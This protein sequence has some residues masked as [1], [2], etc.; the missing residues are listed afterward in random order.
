MYR[1]ELIECWKLSVF[2]S[3]SRMIRGILQ[4]RKVGHCST[5]WLI[6]LEKLTGSSWKFCQRCIFG[7]A[8]VQETHRE[9][10]YRTWRFYDDIV[11]L[12]NTKKTCHVSIVLIVSGNISPSL[13]YLFL[14]P[15]TNYANSKKIVRPVFLWENTNVYV[16]PIVT[17]TSAPTLAVLLSESPRNLSLF[18]IISF[19]NAFGLVLY[20]VHRIYTVSGK[21]VPLDFLP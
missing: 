21:K 6:S 13:L 7:Q 9:M 14:G 16:K 1:E 8:I 5:I 15:F 4:H 3:G 2:R 10:R 19:L 18:P 20:S 17:V 12:L 11:H